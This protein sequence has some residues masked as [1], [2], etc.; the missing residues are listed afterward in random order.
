[1]SI[2]SST[3]PSLPGK[4]EMPCYTWAIALTKGKVQQR[5]PSVSTATG[6]VTSKWSAGPKEA[7][8]KGKDLQV[9]DGEMV[10]NLLPILPLLPLLRLPITSHLQLLPLSKLGEQVLS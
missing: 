6:Q 1:M 8:K 2:G 10:A 4:V 5:T 7:E 3:I 9:K